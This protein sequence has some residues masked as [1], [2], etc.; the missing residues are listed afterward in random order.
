[1]SIVVLKLALTPALIASVTLA[2]RWRGPA[3]S[4]LLVGLPLTS[5]PVVFFLAHDHSAAFAA[6]GATGTL[7][8]SVSE[9]LFCLAYA[10]SAP[11]GASWPRACA[12]ASAAFLAAPLLSALPAA[13]LPADAAVLATV[14][15]ARAAVGDPGA[16]R[17]GPPSP[18]W[19]IPVRVGTAATFVFALTASSGL[20]AP[21]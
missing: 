2:Q 10:R 21:A 11:T 1:M 7:A 8:G 18:W 19:D 3:F 12:A 5:G 6:A 9:A 20:L 13:R 17:P 14:A 4:G 15:L 16:H